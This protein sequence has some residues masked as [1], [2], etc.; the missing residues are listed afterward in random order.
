[1]NFIHKTHFGYFMYLSNYNKSLYLTYLIFLIYST[2]FKI[3]FN[4]ILIYFMIIFLLII[5]LQL[6]NLSF[7]LFNITF[8]L[9]NASLENIIKFKIV[10]I[11]NF[12]ISWL[13]SIW[14]YLLNFSLNF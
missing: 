12:N 14:I 2:K 7:H 1:M 3:H 5:I 6:F 10:F 13:L 8:Y 4:F 9:I 11:H